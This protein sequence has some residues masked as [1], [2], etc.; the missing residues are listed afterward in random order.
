M[1]YKENFFNKS[2]AR[3]VKKILEKG[4]SVCIGAALRKLEGSSFTEVLKVR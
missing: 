3:Y 1:L 4:V 2:T